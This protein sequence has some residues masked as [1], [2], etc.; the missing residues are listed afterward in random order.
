MHKRTSV[1]Q[2]HSAST[3]I[4]LP[5]QILR[6]AGIG[7]RKPKIRAILLARKAPVP[8]LKLAP[9]PKHKKKLPAL[10]QRLTDPQDLL[11]PPGHN[12]PVPTTHLLERPQVPELLQNPVPRQPQ[13]QIHGHVAAG[14]PAGV[15][16]QLVS[17]LDHLCQG[18]HEEEEERGLGTRPQG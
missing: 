2:T 3:A 8:N 18:D 6:T 14:S 13:T 16:G 7:N 9:R 5:Q 17:V 4:K 15:R 11:D 12:V 1:A 10:L